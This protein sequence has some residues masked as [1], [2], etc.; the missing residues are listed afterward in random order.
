MPL[1]LIVWF[2]EVETKLPL[3]PVENVLIFQTLIN[4]YEQEATFK[5]VG[6]N[7]KCVVRARLTTR[8]D[9]YHVILNHTKVTILS[10]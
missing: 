9:F 1:W 5:T 6:K 4:I 3:Y 10:E 8:W 7:S 2:K